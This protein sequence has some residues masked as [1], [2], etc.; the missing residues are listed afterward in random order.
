MF[1]KESWLLLN[2]L[3][4]WFS[5]Q[6][7]Q[8]F[9]IYFILFKFIFSPWILFFDLFLSFIIV[10]WVNIIP[11][12]YRLKAES[13]YLQQ[14]KS[15][16]KPCEKKAWH[17]RLALTCIEKN[18]HL[19]KWVNWKSLSMNS[20]PQ[21]NILVTRKSQDIWLLAKASS[22]EINL[23]SIRSLVKCC[24]LMSLSIAEHKL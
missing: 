13:S 10:L 16:Q 3:N 6:Q 2:T 20:W 12:V 18:T 4:I 1:S 24:F 19:L 17:E 22:H 23:F 21:R 14:D 15:Y 7:F 11:C 8:H 5:D 9:E